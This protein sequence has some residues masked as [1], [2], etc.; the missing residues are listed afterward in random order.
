MLSVEADLCRYSLAPRLPVPQN[1][2]DFA[3]YS[4]RCSVEVGMCFGVFVQVNEGK[5]Q[6]GKSNPIGYVIQENGCWDWVGA[7]STNGY[8]SWRTSGRSQ[9]AH[10]AMYERH[11]GPIPDGLQID[12]L[13]RNRKC[14]N[15][16]HMEPVTLIEN[17]LR[18]VGF[19]GR[20]RRKTHCRRGHEYTPENTHATVT[21]RGWNLRACRACWRDDRRGKWQERLRTESPE[22]RILRRE[23]ARVHQANYRARHTALTE[24]E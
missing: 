18:G 16:D 3:R 6:H 8:G 12:H 24:G 11:K 19:S 15:P 20:N 14:V 1:I 17:V 23:R 13:C 5:R 10:R 7:V 22:Q 9:P 21:K 2:A 4:G